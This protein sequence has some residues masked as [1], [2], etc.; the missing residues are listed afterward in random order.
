MQRFVSFLLYAI[1]KNFQQ[2]CKEKKIAFFYPQADYCTDNGAMIA[3]CAFLYQQK[4][5]LEKLNP[6]TASSRSSF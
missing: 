1:R 5:L 6:P 4:N 3:F 2:F